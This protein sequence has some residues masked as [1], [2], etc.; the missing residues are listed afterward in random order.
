M[1]F[2]C[3]CLELCVYYSVGVLGSWV[4]FGERGNWQWCGLQ[5]GERS[6]FGGGTVANADGD[7][8]A[9]ILGKCGVTERGR[10]RKNLGIFFIFYLI[11]IIHILVF[12]LYT[13]QTF[14]QN[15]KYRSCHVI[16]FDRFVN[17]LD[18]VRQNKMPRVNQWGKVCHCDFQGAIW[19]LTI[20]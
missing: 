13:W 3:G 2:E 12:F 17:G 9:G 7:G 18:G 19:G 1:V 15:S 11:I 8:A 4:S 10:G 6:G 20:L 5:E 16:V 14:V